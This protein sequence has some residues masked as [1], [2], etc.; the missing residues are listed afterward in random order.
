MKFKLLYIILFWLAFALFMTGVMTLVH[1]ITNRPVDVM[2]EFIWQI[3]FAL[4][5]IPA[6]S[7]VMWIAKQFPLQ[8]GLFIRNG[9]ILFFVCSVLSTVQ[10]FFHSV[11]AYFLNP[12][13]ATYTINVFYT[14]LFYNI[15]TM[16][17][18]FCVLVAMQHAADYYERYREKELAAST[19]E[20]QL[21]QAQMLALK[22]QLSP[23]FL[24]NT[25]NA[26]VALIHKD[27]NLAEEM[28]VRLSDFLRLTLDASGKQIISLK[29][30]LD[31]I[32][33][34]IQI[35][36]VRFGDRL[37]FHELVPT[38]LFDAKVP[39]L[40]LQPLVENAV[41]HGLSQFIQSSFLELSVESSNGQLKITVKDDGTPN[42]Q[43]SVITEGI[44]LSNTRKR[45]ETLYGK[46]S[47]L[48]IIPNSP[49]GVQVIVTIPL[50]FE[51]H[52]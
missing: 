15:D 17:I 24:F 50:S 10:C 38:E 48:R 31:F 44:G 27:P 41:K 18:V 4:V 14:S 52:L 29:E 25:L 28:T 46:Q 36:K 26:I 16:L 12:E 43:F 51:V 21:T 34:Y 37:S 23:H 6:T 30:E 42:E 19:L 39:M 22:M 49:R 8:S 11:T 3:A 13:I 20:A 47:S 45:I 9:F 7:F 33:A 1:P 32:R 40:V 2:G 35:E 5:W